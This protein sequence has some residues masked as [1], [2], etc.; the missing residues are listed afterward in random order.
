MATAN[1]PQN[2][3][4]TP[5]WLDP[6]AA[7]GLAHGAWI[8]C[9]GR[10]SFATSVIRALVASPHEISCR[11]AAS[12]GDGHDVPKPERNDNGVPFPLG[13]T[14]QARSVKEVLEKVRQ[15]EVVRRFPSLDHFHPTLAQKPRCRARVE[16]HRV[17]E[18]KRGPS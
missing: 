18:T 2:K 15:R 4:G 10:D 1:A 5:A 12:L 14:L 3:A 7:C 17:L 8:R 9:A 16:Q 6:L 13:N 11:T